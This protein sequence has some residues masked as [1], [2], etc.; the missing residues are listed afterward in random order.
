MRYPIT[1]LTALL[2]GLN[3]G[4]DKHQHGKRIDVFGYSTSRHL[5]HP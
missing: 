3:R 5:A 4:N 2:I 1:I